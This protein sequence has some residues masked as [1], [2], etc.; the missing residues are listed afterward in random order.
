VSE[1]PE[2]PPELARAVVDAAHVKPR[3][4]AARPAK[5]HP[6]GGDPQAFGAALAK[7]LKDRGWQQPAAE[8]TVFGQWERVVGPEV[9]EHSRPVRLAGT[10]LTIEADSTAWATQL[11]LLAGSLLKQ[12]AA[13]VGHG[14]V[15]SLRIH[16]PAAPSWRRGPLRAPGPGP[17]DTYG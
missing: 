10:E 9:A 5:P 1:E 14:V 15:K 7:L 12:I 13:E 2:P 11:R 4:R 3:R 8:A 16:G 17:R 6:G